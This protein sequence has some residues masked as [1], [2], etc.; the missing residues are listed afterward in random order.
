MTS[1]QYEKFTAHV[2][3]ENTPEYKK[4]KEVS[5]ED[6]ALIRYIKSNFTLTSGDKVLDIGGRE[7]YISSTVQEPSYV[8]IIDPDPRL[9]IIKPLKH[10]SIPLEQYHTEEKFKLIVC[11]HVLGDFGRVNIQRE[12]IEKLL[13][14][15]APGGHLI[16]C[17]NTNEGF[18]DTL[19]EFSIKNLNETRYDYFDEKI[20]LPRADL[21]IKYH[22]F[23][24]ELEYGSFEALARCCWVLFGTSGQ[25]INNIAKL[26][27]PFLKENIKKPYFR[28]EERI[29]DISKAN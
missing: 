12:M 9:Q 11:S 20:V 4:F 26:Y 3:E 25:D 2:R 14:F 8:T 22:D 5:R 27:T 1:L 17:Y 16:L 18:M 10:L 19:L 15:L 28:L 21:N 6:A 29:L 7:G 23:S 24:V 13:G